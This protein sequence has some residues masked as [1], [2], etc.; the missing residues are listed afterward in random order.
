MASLIWSSPADRVRFDDYDLYNRSTAHTLLAF[1]SALCRRGGPACSILK[2]EATCFMLGHRLCK[3][4]VY[5]GA[6]TK[7]VQ[8]VSG[9]C[10]KSQ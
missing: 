2:I 3:A 7:V 1:Y 9:V 10:I 4:F 8:G 6:F 5:I